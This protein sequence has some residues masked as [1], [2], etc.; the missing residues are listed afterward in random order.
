MRTLSAG[1]VVLVTRLDRLAR[2]TRDLL[3]TLAA[4]A[5][6]QAGFCSLQECLGGYDDPAWPLDADRPG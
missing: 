5:E 4:F 1:D 2:S 6:K 3:N